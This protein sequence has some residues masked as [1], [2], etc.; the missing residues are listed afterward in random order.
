MLPKDNVQCSRQQQVALFHTKQ[1]LSISRGS[2]VREIAHVRLWAD[3]LR[4]KLSD[5]M[6]SRVMLTEARNAE[7]RLEDVCSECKIKRNPSSMF[8]WAF[9]WVGA[10][11]RELVHTIRIDG[12]VYICLHVSYA[13]TCACVCIH[14]YAHKYVHAR[15]HTYTHS[16]YLS[17]HLLVSACI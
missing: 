11:T 17:S 1:T 7:A 8:V 5:D 16:L 10:R 15:R 2:T 6:V 12:C 4:K 13:H 14:T 3:G 9:G